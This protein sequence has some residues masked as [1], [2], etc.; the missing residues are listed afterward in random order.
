MGMFQIPTELVPRSRAY[1]PQVVQ[2]WHILDTSVTLTYTNPKL[3]TSFLWA[4]RLQWISVLGDPVSGM[5]F[6]R[7]KCLQC[8]DS[9]GLWWHW[10]TGGQ[11]FPETVPRNRLPRYCEVHLFLWYNIIRF[12][13][14]LSLQFITIFT[15]ITRWGLN[16]NYQTNIFSMTTVLD[17][18]YS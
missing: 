5:H 16:Y 8:S 1:S 17:C 9:R 13:G 6:T 18:Y 7:L 12:G 2:F 15:P 14:L 11:G 3:L 4:L 10:R